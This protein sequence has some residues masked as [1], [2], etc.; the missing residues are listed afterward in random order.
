ME[1]DISVASIAKVR[2]SKEKVEEEETKIE[3]N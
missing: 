3:T 2:E 1:E